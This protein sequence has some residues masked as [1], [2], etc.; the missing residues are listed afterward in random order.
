[1][2]LQNGLISVIMTNYN[3]PEAYLREAIDSILRQTYANFEFI[4]ID[5]CS[6]DDSVNVLRSYRDERIILLQNEENLGL[7]KSLNRALAIAKGEFI[8][9]MDSDDISEPSRFEMQTA[10]L[11]EHPRIIVCGTWAKLFGDWKASGYSH[12]YI[13]RELPAREI[14]RI[15]LLFGN[16]PGIVHPSAMFRHAMLKEWN[17]RYNENYR[18]A[19]DYRMWVE[20]TKYADCAI[21]SQVLLNY[22]IHKKAIT[23]KNR[24]EQDVCALNIMD[25]QLSALGLRL[26]DDTIPYHSHYLSKRQPYSEGCLNWIRQIIA[27]NRKKQIYDRKA[28]ESLIW[29]KWAEIIYFGLKDAGARDRIRMLGTLPLKYFPELLHIRSA[30]RKKRSTHNA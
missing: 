26:T 22:R 6:T 18:Y 11:R 3:T 30:R 4:I 20:C 15:M 25:E 2:A 8:A 9:R 21:V 14:H 1:M 17:I 7:T 10:Y 13:R 29:K 27:A 16:S 19:Q 5:D 23:S 28:L 12:E 24:S